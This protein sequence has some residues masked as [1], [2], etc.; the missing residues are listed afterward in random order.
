ML[1]NIS[2]HLQRKHSDKPDVKRIF[3]IENKQVRKRQLI[4]MSAV[5]DHENNVRNLK[6]G[7]GEILLSRRPTQTFDLSAYGP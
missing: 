6:E 5:M 4:L 3:E 1:S 7:K 2:Q